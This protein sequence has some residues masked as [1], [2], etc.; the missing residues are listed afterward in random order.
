[1]SGNPFDQFDQGP[2]IQGMVA[3][4][5]QRQGVDPSLALRVAKQESGFR[6]DARSPAGAIGPMQLMPGTARDLGVDPSDPAQ[7][8]QGGVRYLKQQLDRF[9][10]PRLALAAYN[11]GPG[12]VQKYGGVPPYAETKAYVAATAPQDA[13]NPFDQFDA[14]E[15]ASPQPQAPAKAP[16]EVTVSR[17]TSPEHMAWVAAG[18][19]VAP[20]PG[21]SPTAN[22][23]A[24]A[25]DGF[26]QPFVQLGHDV[27]QSYR[28]KTAQATKPNIGAAF[29]GLG[30]IPQ[31]ASDVAG[32]IG[33]P[34]SA[35][36][37]PL[38]GV[39]S[40]VLPAPSATHTEWHGL[41]PH[42]YVDG[43]MSQPQAQSAI[44]DAINTAL[45]GVRP[46]GV[47]LPAA[48][49]A[50]QAQTAVPGRT[51]T[52]QVRAVTPQMPLPEPIPATL[53]GTVQRL[54][55][56]K[57]SAYAKVDNS[58]FTFPPDAINNLAD[59]L[60][61]QVVARGGPEAA[62]ASPQSYSVIGRLRAL[63]TQPDGVPLSQL[64][65]VRSDIWPLMMEGGGPDKFY[66]GILRSGIDAAINGADA[67]YIADARAANARYEKASAV[68]DRVRSAELQAG[69]ANS[70]ENLGNAIR[71]KLSPL[72]DPLHGAQIPNLTPAEAQA[73]ENVVV[74]DPTQNRLR[75]LSNTLRSP[76]WTG[77]V[78]TPATVIGAAIGGPGGAAVGSGLAG[79]GMQVTGQ[80]LR[81]AAEKRAMNNV[82]ALIDLISQGGLISPPSSMFSGRGLI[83]GSVL[84]EPLLHPPGRSA[85]SGSPKSNGR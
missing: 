75:K 51:L 12:A 8:V 40:R 7:N 70:G 48:R 36:L 77:A 34:F 49:V 32:T 44:E 41:I 16:I 83:G 69:R 9:G 76:M 29:A 15:A 5:A 13:A 46:A 24:D 65:R 52:E 10:D 71:Q 28:A 72:I 20:A 59:T 80:L 55:A 73:L 6:P 47:D 33:A 68:A 74:G 38:A 85:P 3:A 25:W 22:V 1:M 64:D 42:T 62:K 66:G 67:P 63:A 37:H 4:E 21:P 78:T 11:A 82:Q 19:P 23:G 18:K 45:Q 60:E 53:P 31:I 56:E 57:A 27:A 35:A 26:A 43:K 58:G 54:K 17:S 2:D 14:S 79:G 81:K 39:L 84:A 50:S 61:Q 30:D